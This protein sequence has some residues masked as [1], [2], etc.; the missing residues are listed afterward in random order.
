MAVFDYKIILMCL[1]AIVLLIYKDTQAKLIDI[2]GLATL[3]CTLIFRVIPIQGLIRLYKTGDTRPVPALFYTVILLNNICWC[4]FGIKKE[5]FVI[6]I[7]HLTGIM[8]Y[9]IFLCFFIY[10]SPSLKQLSKVIIIVLIILYPTSLLYMGYNYLT[11]EQIEI[12]GTTVGIAVQCSLL[13]PIG[14]VIINKNSVYID[15]SIASMHFLLNSLNMAYAYLFDNKFLIMVC[16]WGW[17]L[18]I[19][20]IMLCLFV[21]KID[22]NVNEGKEIDN[23]N[24]K[25]EDKS[26][27]IN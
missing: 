7:A 4:L 22:A 25:D 11:I 16:A 10:F 13:I 19:V 26:K 23:I 21:K 6:I 12:I 24:N 3:I 18:N 27:K 8:L 14:Q 17:F 20:Q 15:I 9:P 2:V 5:I 1:L